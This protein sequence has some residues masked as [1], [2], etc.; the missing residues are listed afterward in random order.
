MLHVY[1]HIHLH[2]SDDMCVLSF[3]ILVYV[4]SHNDTFFVSTVCLLHGTVIPS[5]NVLEH[6]QYYATLVA[7][8]VFRSYNSSSTSR[9]FP[10]FNT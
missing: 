2:Y 1:L 9:D 3:E 8:V 6:N 4:S 5:Y 7:W 10:Q